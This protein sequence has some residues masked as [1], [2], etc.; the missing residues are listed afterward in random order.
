MFPAN[1]IG[2]IEGIKEVVYQYHRP[3]LLPRH[4]NPQ[5][6]YCV[7]GMALVCMIIERL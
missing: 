2:S 3:L 1:T 6:A 5:V 4:K 7:F